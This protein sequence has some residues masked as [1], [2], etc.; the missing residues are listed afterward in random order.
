MCRLSLHLRLLSFV[1]I[2]VLG[3]APGCAGSSSGTTEGEGAEGSSGGETEVDPIT[4]PPLAETLQL[5][6]TTLIPVPSSGTPRHQ[7][8]AELQQL[9]AKVEEASAMTPPEFE[10]EA[11]MD[12]VT[13]WTDAEF[14][15]WA[16]A[17][18][19]AT[20]AIVDSA[21]VFTPNT[22][23]AG[24]AGALVGYSLEEFVIAFRGAPVPVE[25][26]ADPELLEVFLNS[27]TEASQPIALQ[28]GSA[29]GVC[30]RTLAPL[31]PESVWVEW[32]QYCLFRA[33]EVNEVYRLDP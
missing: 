19:D 5:P 16:Q 31:G 10:G 12:A 1:V 15:P 21:R 9:W 27:L 6:T 4:E 26:A 13:A 32:A 7:L 2:A 8:S 29:Y 24:V 3:A 18:I 22:P 33:E 30:A 14:S 11:T 20:L 17:R 23:E 25:V 28:A